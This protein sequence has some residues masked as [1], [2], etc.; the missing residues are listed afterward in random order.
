MAPSFNEVLQAAQTALAK[1]QQ[2]ETDIQKRIQEIRDANPKAP[3][4]DAE[5]KE[6][7]QLRDELDEVLLAIEKV[8]LV[9]VLRIDK[10]PELEKLANALSKITKDLQAKTAHFKAIGTGAQTVGDMLQT[11]D[12]LVAKAKALVDKAKAHS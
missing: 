9:T 8:E 7:D 1:L 11:L 4:T 2:R 12:G 5:K 3:F 6:L 10:A